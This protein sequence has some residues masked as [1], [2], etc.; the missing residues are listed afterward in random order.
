MARLLH[1]APAFAVLDEAT[2]AVSHDIE[3][4]LVT[5]CHRRGITLIS[6]SH[7][8]PLRAYH[9]QCLKLLGDG[10]GGWELLDISADCK[11]RPHGV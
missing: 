7:R 1:H 6:V 5:A 8:A 10:K 11:L 2:A 4:A 9:M 3:E